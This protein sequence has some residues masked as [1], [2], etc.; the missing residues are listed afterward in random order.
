LLDDCPKPI[1]IFTAALVAAIITPDPTAISMLI[2]MGAL[3]GLYFL[4]VGLLK[5]FGR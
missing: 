2:V 5:V 3:T 4:S 1:A